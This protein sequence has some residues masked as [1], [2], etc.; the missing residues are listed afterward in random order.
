MKNNP[1][2]RNFLEFTKKWM[3]ENIHFFTINNQTSLLNQLSQLIC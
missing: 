3:D 2:V 1:K